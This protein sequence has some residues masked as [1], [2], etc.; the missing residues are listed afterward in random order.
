MKGILIHIYTLLF[1]VLCISCNNGPK[2]I[3]TQGDYQETPSNSENVNED[4][5][6]QQN[7]SFEDKSLSDNIHH[8]IVNEVQLTEKYAFAH[9]SEGANQYWI[10]TRVKTL[11]PNGHYYYTKGLLK[12]NYESKELNKVFDQIYL[13]SNLVSADHKKSTDAPQSKASITIKE[14][15]SELDITEI[16]PEEGSIKIAEIVARP[17]DFKDKIVQI[18][19]KCV[20]INPNIMERNWIHLKDGS[21]DDYDLVVTSGTFIKEGEVVTIRA[22]VSLNMDYGAGYTYPLI[23]EDGEVIQ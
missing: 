20:K 1:L 5:S 9:V 13:V 10:A 22:K 4:N 3:E 7:G 2:F 19:G 23:L 8:I 6:F 16:A 18:T 15:G 12:N 17:D 14:S 21:K 11:E